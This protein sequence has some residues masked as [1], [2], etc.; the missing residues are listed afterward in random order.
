MTHVT[1]PILGVDFTATPTTAEFALGTT[2]KG[3]DG[4]EWVYVQASGAITQY[5]TVGIDE[6]Y[7]AAA[8]TKAIVDDG[9]GI[10]FAQ[11]AFTDNDYGWIAKSGTNIQAR[12]ATGCLPDVAL[13]TSGTAGVI[14]DDASGQTKIDGIVAVTTGS[15]S[16]V[17]SVEVIATYPRSATF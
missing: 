17:A 3:S 16:G 14:D 9:H 7:Q 2:V 12:V 4:T 11:V 8:V 13:Y 15:A 5:D 1:T 10:G 6:N